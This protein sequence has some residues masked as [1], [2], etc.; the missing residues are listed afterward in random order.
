SF[1]L[2]DEQVM[3]QGVDLAPEKFTVFFS[4]SS[5]R[6]SRFAATVEA[7]VEAVDDKQNRY[8]VSG[9]S[10]GFGKDDTGGVFFREAQLGFKGTLARDA[11]TLNITV[12]RIAAFERGPWE[13][14]V[15]VPN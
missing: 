4:P 11:T 12:S 13:F 2:E 1:P 14:H 6:S 8:E 9:G 15:K 3:A 5:G 10:L 7:I